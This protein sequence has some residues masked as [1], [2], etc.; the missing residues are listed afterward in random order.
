MSFKK[1]EQRESRMHYDEALTLD[2][3]EA[4]SSHAVEWRLDNLP[5]SVFKLKF[6]LT[7]ERGEKRGYGNLSTLS[8]PPF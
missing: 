7:S 5:S 1:S 8:P 3:N 6:A 2:H 4:F